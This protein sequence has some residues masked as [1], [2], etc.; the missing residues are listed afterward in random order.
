M[1]FL[2]S[3]CVKFNMLRVCYFLKSMIYVYVKDYD[4][5]NKLIKYS[6]SI[7]NGGRSTS[8]MVLGT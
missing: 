6:L 8:R 5:L 3:Y 1:C 4:S 7:D 2:F